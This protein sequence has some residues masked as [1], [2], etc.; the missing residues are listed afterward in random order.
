MLGYRQRR[1]SSDSTGYKPYRDRLRSNLR[2]PTLEPDTLFETAMTAHKRGDL[3]AARKAYEEVLEND[4]QHAG[5]WMNLGVL[6]RATG[7][8]EAALAALRRAEGLAPDHEGILYNLGNALMDSDALDA[9]I[10]V[11]RRALQTAPT[12]ADAYNNLGEAFIRKGDRKAAIAQFRAGLER[13]STHTGLL[14]NLGNALHHEGESDA[15]LSCLSQALEASPNSITIRRNLGNTLR[16]LGYLSAAEDMLQG[17]LERAPNDANAQVLL[18]FCKFAQGEFD[19]AWDAYVHR[20]RSDDHEPARHYEAPHWAGQSLAGKRLLIWGEQAVGDE[21]M[22]AT[23]YDEIANMASDIHVET[24]FRL[25]PL[26]QRSFPQFKIYARR[27]PPASTLLQQKFDYQIAAGDLGRFLRRTRTDFAASQPYLEADADHRMRFREAYGAQA[28]GRPIIGISWRSGSE[29]A[30]VP[31]SIPL[32]DLQPLVADNSFMFVNLQYGE[33]DMDL[34]T[35]RNMGC[36]IIDDARVDPLKDM[37]LAAA[38]IAAMDLVV[39]AANTAVHLGGA[40]G[41]PT[42]VALSKTPDWR[43]LAE[44]MA[45]PWYPNVRLFRQTDIADWRKPVAQIISAL[46]ERQGTMPP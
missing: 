19:A 25:L 31:R 11:Y 13:K 7:A 1:V 39:S 36:A 28:N 14:V 4:P 15:A 23:M 46:R 32:S 3:D 6:H 43:W 40:L 20:W 18:A 26:F 10:G 5:A 2:M 8:S 24:E 38:Q 34:K 44:G 30:G 21:L 45:S 37:D 33:T 9:A 17:A 27:T 16:T 41:I 35:M 22:F 12:F 29:H 42:W